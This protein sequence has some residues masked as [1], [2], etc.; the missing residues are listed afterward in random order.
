[1][2]QPAG[3]TTKDI[4]IAFA[5]PDIA[6]TISTTLFAPSTLPMVYHSKDLKSYSLGY[7]LLGNPGNVFHSFYVFSL[8]TARRLEPGYPAHLPHSGHDRVH[9]TL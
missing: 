5:L 9:F 3:T 1:L 7:L 6:G 2:I 4:I 8:P